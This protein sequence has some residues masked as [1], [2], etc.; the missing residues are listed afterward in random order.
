MF[1]P[2]MPCKATLANVSAKLSRSIS[3]ALR[4]SFG[5]SP[6]LVAA[7]VVPAMLSAR[8]DHTIPFVAGFERF[9]RHEDIPSASA[10]RLLLT[11]L[12]CT[13]CHPGGASLTPKGGPTLA[14]AGAR[15]HAPWIERF[16][17]SP[18][19]VHGGSTMPSMLAALPEGERK[20]TASALTAYLMTLVEPYPEP[21][22]TGANPV[23]PEFYAWGDSQQG[24]RLFHTIGCVACHEPAKDYDVV[25]VQPSEL[26]K[27]LDTLDPDELKELGLSSTARKVDSI[28]LPVLAEK[29][30]RKSLTYFLLYPEH[31]RPSSRMP[32][33]N[34]KPVEAA[35]IAAYLLAAP[36]TASSPPN[37]I[38]QKPAPQLIARGKQLFVELRCANCHQV[39]S[40]QIS[41]G[42]IALPP[43]QIIASKPLANLQL[44]APN[45]CVPADSPHVDT[46]KAAKFKRG[47]PLYQ[48]DSAQVRA[49]KTALTP[50][51]TPNIKDHELQLQLMQ[52]NC[53][54]C[55]ERDDLGGVD[56][57][58]KT[59]FETVNNVDLGDEGRLPP[60][61][62][63]VGKRLNTA[64]MERV[65][66]GDGKIRPHMTI[67]MPVYG[68]SFVKSLP[69]AFRRQDYQPSPPF[70]GFAQGDKKSQIEAG[71]QL[72][73]AGCVQCHSFRGHALPGVVGVD[74]NDIASRVQPKWLHD[75]LLDPGAL[76]PRTRMPTFFPEA[77]SQH[78]DILGGDVEQQLAAMAAY[79][80]DLANQPLPLK[81]EEARAQ[82]FELIPT[83]KP[84]VMRTFM[85]VGGLHSIAVGFP[86]KWHFAFDAD[87][88]S[89]AEAWQGRFLD[90]ESTWFDRFSKPV[91]P[92]GSAVISFPAGP[93]ISLLEDKNS[94]WPSTAQAAKVRFRGYELD[95]TGVPTFRYDVASFEVSERIEPYIEDGAV[96]GLQRM[97]TAK[98]SADKAVHSKL[99]FRA[100]VDKKP[101]QLTSRPASS[102]AALVGSNGLKVILM[103][104]VPYGEV[105]IMAG[106]T[107][108]N[109]PFVFEADQSADLELLYQWK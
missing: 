52:L 41:A 50:Q 25:Q 49:L 21:K 88:C 4:E 33:F 34:L 31:V 9:G 100:L 81:I 47:Q 55:H 107:E 16:L 93:A 70:K 59:Y 106:Q 20:A 62:T 76:K 98:R 23:P 71:R 2:L 40:R 35:D 30:S 24:K 103:S 79:L 42:Q 5:I 87:R 95:S 75:F 85:P 32:S 3:L 67:R 83:E 80:G 48:L 99:W 18:S 29:F 78:P 19:S 109:I 108:W 22:A 58:R 102:Q 105:R 27:L 101:Q 44:E 12:S 6:I 63:G 66:R 15:L 1:L 84:I 92:L 69:D 73:D 90:A 54:A 60:T 61:L 17:Q 77:K 57:Y 13:A 74:L 37:P 45:S 10:G 86:V 43:A 89:I 51:A 91:R 56:R 82:N 64:W 7:L 36:Q 97:L 68:P 11:E 28:P 26:D 46:A 38:R 94:A 14:G 65:L 104:N 8:A 39:S 72:M 96:V 53:F